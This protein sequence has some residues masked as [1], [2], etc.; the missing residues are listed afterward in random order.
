MPLFCTL[1]PDTLTGCSGSEQLCDILRRHVKVSLS[2]LNRLKGVDKLI[3]LFPERLD[4]LC[5]ALQSNTLA[6]MADQ[7]QCW[8]AFNAHSLGRKL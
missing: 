2:E 6:R 3:Q 4:S 5:G 1:R 7:L 8:V